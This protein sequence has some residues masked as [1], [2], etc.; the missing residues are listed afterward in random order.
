MSRTV[1][2]LQART[3]SHRLPGK[4]LMDLRGEPMMARVVTRASRAESLD[5]VV[6]ATSTLP[7][8]DAIESLCRERG[9]PVHRGSPDDLLDRYHQAAV[10]EGADVVVRITCDCPLIEP[11]VIDRT[12]RLFRESGVD[13]A[14]SGG[15][16]RS[17]PRG[18]DTEVCSF[19]A[20]ERAWRED[21][22]PAWREHV[23][24][25]I[26][27]HPELFTMKGLVD[28]TDRSTM[29]WTVDTPE[30]MAFVRRIYESFDDDRFTWRQ[31]LAL[32]ERHPEWLEINRS[33]AQK[34]V[35]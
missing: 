35:G 22:D 7:G 27:R 32:L 13:Y 9:W 21:K 18:L 34:E 33:I 24:P 25:Y 15:P 10:A 4:V 1:A 30:D 23:T 26:Y 17:F 5:R 31:V 16:P 14:S 11:E 28:D 8:D 29:R 12:V 3:G 2:I 6:V 19:A 20:L